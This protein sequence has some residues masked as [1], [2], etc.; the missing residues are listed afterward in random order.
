VKLTKSEIA[1]ANRMGVP[2]EEY[3]KQVAILRRKA[4]G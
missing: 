1:I 4:N 2:L 3:A